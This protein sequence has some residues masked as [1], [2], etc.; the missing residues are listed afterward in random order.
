M[1]KKHV[2]IMSTMHHS[3]DVDQEGKKKPDM[4][5]YY[6]ETKGGVDIF[7]YMCHSFSC[8]RKTRRWQMILFYNLLDTATVANYIIY[9]EVFPVD[10]KSYKDRGFFNELLAKDLLLEYLMRR[11]ELAKT[12]KR[13]NLEYEILKLQWSLGNETVTRAGEKRKAV[14]GRCSRCPR[15][16][17][18]KVRQVCSKCGEFVYNDHCRINKICIICHRIQVK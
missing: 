12:T 4:V 2:V 1:I 13:V 15:K 5:K 17:D 16:K 9:K 18:R 7:D 6:N 10:T 14:K 3:A 11:M 8:N